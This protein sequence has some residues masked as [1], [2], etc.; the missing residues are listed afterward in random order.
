PTRCA[1]SACRRTRRTSCTAPPATS[2]SSSRRPRVRRGTGS[3]TAGSWSRSTTPT[4]RSFPT[5]HEL[6][7]AVRG[8]RRGRSAPDRH[9]APADP[10]RPDRR[11]LAGPGPPAGR[12][13]R[14]FP[15]A[16]EALRT[17]QRAGGASDPEAAAYLRGLTAGY[18]RR[19]AATRVESV[20][21][22]PATHAVPVRATAQVLVELVGGA[23]RELL[24]MTYSAKPYP[25][26]REALGAAVRRGVEVSVVVET[27]GGAGSAL[28]GA[29]PAAAFAGV[30]GIRLWHWPAARRPEQGAKMQIGRAHV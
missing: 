22:G 18:A 10:R 1:P 30:P 26:L 12:A 4:W 13:G 16:V 6:A 5:C 8:R 20:W 28:A 25:P 23:A 27:L 11:R 24:L 14:R 15:E 21:S 19:S 17:A 9:R 7:V 2:A 29:E 3:S